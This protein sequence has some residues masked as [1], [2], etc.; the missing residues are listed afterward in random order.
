MVDEIPLSKPHI[1]EHDIESVVSVLKS[2]RLALGPMQEQ[3]EHAIAGVTRRRHAVA[4]SSGTA[5]LH[6]VL[7]AMGIGPGDEVITP[8]FSFVAS[9]N[10]ICM[11]GATPVFVDIDTK[12]LNADPDQIEA[13][14][15]PRTKAI[16][17]VECF[18]NPAHM[19]TYRRIADKHEI[20][21]IEDAC[22]GLGGMLNGKPVGSFGHAAVFG[23]Y[24]NKQITTGEGGVIVTDDDHLADRCRSLRNQGRATAA[25]AATSAGGG[26]L[27]SGW[28]AFERLGYNYRLDEMSAALG[29]TQVAK[30]PRLLELRR[31][32]A[33]LYT[34]RLL[35]HADIIL[36]NV[37]DNVEMSW[38]VFVIRLSATYTSAERD[39]IIEGMHRHDVGAAP[40]FPCIHLQKH[41]RDHFGCAEGDFPVAE[42]VSQR[43]IAIPFYPG[44]TK[45]DL[46][47]VAGT[48]GLMISRENLAKRD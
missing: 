30:L 6:A 7:V 5:G 38:F 12:T 28:M 46:D 45:R 1:D 33:D 36:P 21:L 31:E 14:I 47:F 3:F 37:P 20:R 19:D 24:P 25:D 18:G 16:L 22:E 43:T 40:Y 2:G 44:M 4:V 23:F 48:L 32:L 39:R 17:A 8:T 9:A 27:G 13:K 29:V 10:S 42:S 41:Y 35:D 15:T 11:A 34:E 26:Q